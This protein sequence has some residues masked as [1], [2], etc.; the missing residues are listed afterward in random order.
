MIAGYDT[1][2]VTFTWGGDGQLYVRP[3][4]DLLAVTNEPVNLSIVYKTDDTEAATSSFLV[5][6][7]TACDVASSLPTGTLDQMIVM[8]AGDSTSVNID[9]DYRDGG[10]AI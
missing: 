4:P 5:T 3:G 9:I 2:K 1:G 7:D 10:C 6:I 8:Y